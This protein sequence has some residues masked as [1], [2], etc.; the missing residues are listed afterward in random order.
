MATETDTVTYLDNERLEMSAWLIG[1]LA[2]LIAF[3][4]ATFIIGED[5]NQRNA[6]GAREKTEQVQ[7]CTGIED[8]V[9]AL[10][11]TQEVN[12]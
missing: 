2:A 11:C 7:A 8:A 9:A 1:G 5:L 3:V 12:E 10:A 6:D 4:A